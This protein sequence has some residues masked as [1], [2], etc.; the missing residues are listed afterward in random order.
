MTNYE[1]NEKMIETL[2]QVNEA[3]HAP[4]KPN[5]TTVKLQNNL[6]EVLEIALDNTLRIAEAPSTP[7]GTTVRVL[8]IL[9][10]G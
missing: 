6:T 8:S 9:E 1:R 3:A 4:A 5:G 7:N 10:N 2:R